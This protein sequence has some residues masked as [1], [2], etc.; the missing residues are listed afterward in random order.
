MSCHE[1]DSFL[2]PYLDG[3]LEAEARAEIEEHLARCSS[4][5]THVHEESSF[6]Q[7]FKAR[8][9][10]ALAEQQAPEAL[11]ER[12]QL[13]LR[14]VQRRES[15]V[16]WASGGAAAAALVIVVAGSVYYVRASKLDKLAESAARFNAK[17]VPLDVQAH[18]ATTYLS[19]QLERGIPL[20]RF[21]NAVV[22]GAR[23]A[24]VV[25]KPAGY[26][27]Y[28]VPTQRG[29][30]RRM[31]LFVVDDSG[32]ELP[33]DPYPTVRLANRKGYNVA[34]WREEDIVYELVSDLEESDI[35]ALLQAR[36]NGIAR[37]E[38]L[39]PANALMASQG[40]Q[41][42]SNVA[43]GMIPASFSPNLSSDGTGGGFQQASFQH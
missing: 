14:T 41:D 23:L 21:P 28:D 6:Q 24:N 30:M 43:S 19:E 26:V 33:V 15:A 27:V 37:A 36:A 3:E 20:P 5:A 1:L 38:L 17:T 10:S 22:R 8:L 9:K 25:E 16:R 32:G 18:L 7:G 31:G 11:R 29:D 40:R 42:P 39:A 35:R 4:C 34:Q 13:G 12:V 2:L